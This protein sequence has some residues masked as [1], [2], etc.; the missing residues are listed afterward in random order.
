MFQITMLI[1]PKHPIPGAFIRKI[2]LMGNKHFSQKGCLP[3]EIRRAILPA[4]T[5]LTKPKLL[6]KC[7]HGKTQNANQSFNGM[8][9]ER[10]HYVGLGKLEFGV[11]DATANFNYGKKA[12]IDIFEGLKLYPGTYMKNMCASS[13]KKRKSLS[14]LKAFDKCKKDGK[15]NKP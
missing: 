2:K 5:G 13:N 4:Y 12:C 10:I 7:L 3:V 6:I 15:S 9:W 8:I 1:A 11:Y 14:V